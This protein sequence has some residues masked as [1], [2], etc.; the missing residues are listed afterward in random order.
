MEFQQDST[1]GK[2]EEFGNKMQREIG[3][4]VDGLSQS[5][6][7]VEHSTS[8]ALFQD[9]KSRIPTFNGSKIQDNGSIEKNECVARLTKRYGVK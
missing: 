7:K 1:F 3:C 5:F 9:V 4:E 8:E 6:T 2:V